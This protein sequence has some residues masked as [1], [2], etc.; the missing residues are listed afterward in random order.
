MRSLFRRYRE[1]FFVA[2]LLG[3]P[4]GVFL[5]KAKKGHDLNLLDRGLLFLTAP[6]ERAIVGLSFFAT[7]TFQ[8]YLALRGVRE[9][10][11]SLR[12]DLV[13]ARSEADTA[14]ELRSENDRLKHLLEFEDKQTPTR[15]LVAQV[16]AVGASPH[17]HL[18]RISRGLGDGV[19]K[20][21]PVVSPDGVVGTVVQVTASYADVQ[22]I[23][24][25]IAAVPALSERTRGRST[26]KGTGDLNRCKLE[27]AVR[28]DDLRD[29]DL[30]LTAPV[31]GF[32][33]KGLRIG[34]VAN[35]VHHPTGMF[36]TGDV[37]PSVDFSRLDEVLVV[38]DQIPPLPQI[39]QS[40]PVEPQP[41]ARLE[42][43]P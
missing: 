22:L 7:D 25:P 14:A 35:L 5:A 15:L 41:A 2:L 42:G 9:Q 43:T 13:R 29:G 21:S 34:R 23:T 16:V 30:L 31:P 6:A 32:F 33:P 3:V 24:S 18:L 8:A 11:L 19:L 38:L 28:S 20:G 4:F 10:N 39:P 12:R 26:V 27:Y 40:P 1:L 36:L 37:L 17:S